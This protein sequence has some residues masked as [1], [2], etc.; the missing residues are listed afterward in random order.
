MGIPQDVY[1]RG[2]T[3]YVAD[4]QADLTMFNVSVP[5]N[6]FLIRN[7]DTHDDDFAKGIYISPIDTFPYAYIADMDGKIQALNIRDTTFTLNSTIGSNQNLEDVTGLMFR[8]TLWILSVSSGFNRRFLSFNQI[9]YTPYPDPYLSQNFFQ[10]EMPA[11]VFGLDADSNYV[12]VACGTAGLGIYDISDIFNPTL[13]GFLPLSGT[14]L[15]VDVVGNYAY[16]A[17]DRG[18]VHV[19]DVTDKHAPRVVKQVL[20]TG[21]AKDLQVVGNYV[22]VAD[23][24]GGL[25]TID[26]A[27]PD[28]SHIV[29]AYTTPYAY[30]LFA[31]RNNIYLCDR[32]NG[33]LIFENRTAR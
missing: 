8:D 25:K 31:D 20:T 28:S 30:G 3:A 21:R 32:D 2:D 9:L 18:G 16:V 14:A 10:L 12:Y 27:I 13:T 29:A 24:S 19:V 7:I 1:L 22:F 33:L 4:G 17:S 5:S 15:S 11:D 26:V 23:A 6:P